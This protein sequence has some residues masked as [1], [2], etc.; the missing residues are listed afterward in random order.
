LVFGCHF[1]WD[2]CLLLLSLFTYKHYCLKVAETSFLSFR[3]YLSHS[4]PWL[5]SLDAS[6]DTLCAQFICVGCILIV[7]SS[8]STLDCEQ[9]QTTS[10]G[11]FCS[12]CF[13][14]VSREAQRCGVAQDTLADKWEAWDWI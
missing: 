1:F 6:L 2:W 12:P 8:G 4:V 5:H 9:C 11:T 3:S 10:G 7:H 13:I 14:D